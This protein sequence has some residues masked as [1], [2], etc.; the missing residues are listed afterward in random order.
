MY[1]RLLRGLSLIWFCLILLIWGAMNVGKIYNSPVLS[2]IA[3]HE[4]ITDIF[5]YDLRTG[6]YNNVTD[7]AYPEWYLT[8]SQNKYLLYTATVTRTE[9]VSDGLFVMT[10]L[11]QPRRVLTPETLLTFDS[12][13]A[14]NGQSF[15]YFSS[16]PR[17]YSDIYQIHLSDGQTHNLTHTPEQSET[18]P[19]WSPDGQELLFLLDENLYRMDSSTQEQSLF[20]DL[21]NPINNPSWSPDAQYIAFLTAIWDEGRY[22]YQLHT[23]TTDGTNLHQIHLESEPR[24]DAISWSPDSCCITLGLIS[25]ELAIIDIETDNTVYLMG[26]GRR[27]APTWSPDGRWIAFVENR[28][29]HFLDL[30]TD[31]VYQLD[32]QRRVRVPMHW[33][34]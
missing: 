19:I 16:H 30:H 22:V 3:V 18:I 8:W 29:I 2:F 10:R 9:Q 11:G 4:D 20:L 24:A 21:G 17:N 34:P 31:S 5:L 27:F 25:G 13:F 28:A 6:L 12:D 33:M 14:P 1:R 23:I 32:N 7:T 26:E 15:V